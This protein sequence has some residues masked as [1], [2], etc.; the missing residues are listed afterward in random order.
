MSRPYRI[1]KDATIQPIGERPRRQ[2][3]ALHWRS[4]RPA[5]MSSQLAAYCRGVWPGAQI[6]VDPS[7][8]LVESNGTVRADG[9]IFVN[10]R[11]VA[12][13]F[14]NDPAPARSQQEGL[15]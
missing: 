2:R 5:E 6:L 15:L 3:A 7:P 1:R 12:H 14:L 9:S 10:G 8:K 4:G 11:E 13:Y